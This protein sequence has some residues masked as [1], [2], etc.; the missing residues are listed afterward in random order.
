MQGHGLLLCITCETAMVK[1][2]IPSASSDRPLQLVLES[3][4]KQADHAADVVSGAGP[5]CLSH[6]QVC[7]ALHSHLAHVQLHEARHIHIL[8]SV[9]KPIARNDQ[10]YIVGH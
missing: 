7:Q 10:G 9:P 8:Q 6:E 5:L 4:V 1:L 3:P 2:S